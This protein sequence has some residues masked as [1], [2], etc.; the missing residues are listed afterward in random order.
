MKIDRLYGIPVY[1][2]NHKKASA[3]ELARKFEVS[4]RTVQRDIDALCQAGIPVAAES[5]AKGGYSIPDTFRMDSQAITQED[6]GLIFTA[7]KGFSSAMPSPNIASALEKFTALS[8][9]DNERI[10][11]DFSVL[12]E[13]GETLIKQLQTAIRRKCCVR[14]TYTNADNMTRVHTVEPVALVYRWYAW[15]LLAYSTVREDYRTYKLVRM[16]QAE[17]TGLPF[18]ME[19]APAE[20]ILREHDRHSPLA[21]TTVTIRCRPA[22][23]SRAIEYLNGTVLRELEDGECEMKLSVIE[24]EHLWFGTLLALGDEIEILE[25]E[26]IR[27][28]VIR[29]AK[30]ICSLYGQL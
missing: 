27:E 13:G 25:P 23:R 14:F 4:V 7:L 19:H 17:I 29:T 20:T 21:H 9:P 1:L 15:Y 2:L 8:K 24:N 12:R 26:R 18:T 28:R 5:G 10:I 11:L 30:N 22:A 6:Y 3:S 16:E